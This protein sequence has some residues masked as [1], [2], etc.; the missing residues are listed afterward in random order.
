MG[1]MQNRH[2]SHQLGHH[3]HQ[4]SFSSNFR[5][6]WPVSKRRVG[7][8]D[9]QQQHQHLPVA[10]GGQEPVDRALFVTRKARLV[11]PVNTDPSCYVWT[12]IR[13]LPTL[14]MD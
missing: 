3:H 1:L 7:Y 8:G 12:M 5:A 13:H 9:V 10:E 14:Q 4:I 6:W 11:I 2:N